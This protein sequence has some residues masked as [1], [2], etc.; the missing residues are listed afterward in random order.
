MEA[1]K[2]SVFVISARRSLYHSYHQGWTQALENFEKNLK[3]Y[4]YPK[5]RYFQL[6]QN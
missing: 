5:K 3:E 2:G 6:H 4:R 1:I